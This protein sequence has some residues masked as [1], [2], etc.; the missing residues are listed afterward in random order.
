ML[1]DR[2]AP[3]WRRASDLAR[4]G[5]LRALWFTA[6]GELCYRRVEIREYVLNQAVDENHSAARLSIDQLNAADIEQYNAFRKPS[7]PASAARRMRAGH[8]CFIARHSDKIV[9]ASWGATGNARSGYLS[10][11]IALTSD[12]AYTYDLFTAPEW[13][14]RGIAIAVTR[15]L[16]N[17]YR[18]EGKRRVLRVIVP[19]NYAAITGTLGYHS[20]GRMGFLGIG[21]FRLDFCRMNAG[22][23]APGKSRR[24]DTQ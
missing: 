12:E 23:L 22:E 10:A 11:P 17:F 2:I 7:D 24:T 18:A 14:R 15:A 20:I 9:C 5:G 8:R 21:G 1:R 19:E 16:H 3:A 4:E 13:R 6:L